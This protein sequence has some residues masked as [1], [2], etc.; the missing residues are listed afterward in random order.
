MP[1]MNKTAADLKATA[2][3]AS[4]SNIEEVAQ[5]VLD[6][7]AD[8]A[9]G[10]ASRGKYE[11]NFKLDRKKVTTQ[12]Q[13]DAIVAELATAGFAID[14]TEPSVEAHTVLTISWA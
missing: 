8:H 7:V 6:A 5:A 13:V 10:Y 12:A 2:D 11:M 1:Q 3:T 9:A 4:A 14:P